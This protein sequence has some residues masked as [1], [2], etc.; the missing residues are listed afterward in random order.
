M[1]LR[2]QHTDNKMDTTF[3][4]ENFL[5]AFP[6]PILPQELSY[7][8]F[9]VY[10]HFCVSLWTLYNWNHM[11]VYVFLSNFFFTPSNRL[12]RF[13]AVVARGCGFPL[14]LLHRIA[15][16]GIWAL[17][18]LELPESRLLWAL[19]KLF[20]YGYGYMFLLGTHPGVESLE[21]RV[22]GPLGSA[23][24]SKGMA[25]FYI[26][27]SNWKASIIYI[28]KTLVCFLMKH[29]LDKYF[30]YQMTL[31]GDVDVKHFCHFLRTKLC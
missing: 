2:T 20:F 4:W 15:L 22:C 16:C 21:E 11:Q 12:E 29:T 17:A 13:G 25:Q 18:H 6:S 23:D 5:Y 1:Q 24:S 3:P 14:L 28:N 30:M 7:P 31:P 8:D 10:E 26:P 9:S 19:L 27:I